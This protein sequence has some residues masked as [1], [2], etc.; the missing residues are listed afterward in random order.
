MTFKDFTDIFMINYKTLVHKSLPELAKSHRT[1]WL[2]T[3][4]EEERMSLVPLRGDSESTRSIFSFMMIPP[5]RLLSG[6]PQ[7][8]STPTIYQ[9]LPLGGS[10]FLLFSTPSP[11]AFCFLVTIIPSSLLFLK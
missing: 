8:P 1:Y 2:T 9:R 6:S 5:P 11:L 7:E 10:N 3:N 4:R